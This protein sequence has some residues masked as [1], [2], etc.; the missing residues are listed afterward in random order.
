MVCTVF[1][2]KYCFGL[3]DAFTV[4]LMFSYPGIIS[5]EV[6]GKYDKIITC[7]HAETLSFIKF[8]LLTVR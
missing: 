8:Y 2:P 3:T 5:Y 1:V 6:F 7:D 4:L